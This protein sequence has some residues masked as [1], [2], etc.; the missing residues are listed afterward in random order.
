RRPLDDLERDIPADVTAA[1]RHPSMDLPVQLIAGHPPELGRHEIHHGPVRGVRWRAV[2]LR[3]R[4]VPQ[5]PVR[6]DPAPVLERGARTRSWPDERPRNRPFMPV[7]Y[8]YGTSR[9]E[10]L[11]VS[12]G[13]WW[14]S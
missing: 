9:T 12:G 1:A 4:E 13:A 2:R 11:P 10:R 5:F 3:R 6:H 7:T 14:R 8:W